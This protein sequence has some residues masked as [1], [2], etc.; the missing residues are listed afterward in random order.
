M[1]QITADKLSVTAES[2]MA[3]RYPAM[4]R[5]NITL[6]KGAFNVAFIGLLALGLAGLAGVGYAFTID[7]K[8]AIGSWMVGAFA[9][10]GIA[11][12]GLFFTMVFHL[13]NAGWS[14]LI[15]RQFENAAA[16]IPLACLLIIP[17]L[18][19]EGLKDGVMYKWLSPAFE[20]DYLL[21]KK[22]PFLTPTFFFAASAVYML[23]WNFLAWRL[24]KFTSDQ[25]AT[26]D[27]WISLK[28][29][30]FST[31]GMIA[32]A[33]ST[34]FAAFHWLMS[35]DFRFFST[36][37]WIFCILKQTFGSTEKSNTLII[38][39]C[40]LHIKCSFRCELCNL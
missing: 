17:I 3:S 20:G 21:G 5:D 38:T 39:P 25:D 14:A 24:N 1:S 10:L 16:M 15:R 31:I 4:N 29:N 35:L 19:A 36:E 18:V 7:P 23:V 33:L 6:S 30:R 26:G 2:P 12:G 27:R 40:W 8:H 22:K 28:A 34:A 37:E 13:T 9:V 11:L 32:F